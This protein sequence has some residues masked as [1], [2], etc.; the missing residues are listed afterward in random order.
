MRIS[1]T[2]IPP[3]TGQGSGGGV[4]L[5]SFEFR[6]IKMRMTLPPS[7]ARARIRPAHGVLILGVRQALLSL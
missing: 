4:W 1:A 7:V 5:P 2:K 3:L 6:G